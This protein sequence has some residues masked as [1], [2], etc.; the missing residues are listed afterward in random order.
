MTDDCTRLEYAC[1]LSRSLFQVGPK[2]F[3]WIKGTYPPFF[4]LL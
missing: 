1:G 2:I 3:E 4:F